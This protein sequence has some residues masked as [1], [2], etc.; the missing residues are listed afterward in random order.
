MNKSIA[1]IVVALAVLAASLV[2]TAPPA[3][4]APK[5]YASCAKLRAD[6]PKGV[7]RTKAAAQR[8]VKAGFRRPAVKPVVYKKNRRLDPDRDR[9]A[10]EKRQPKPADPWVNMPASSML[11]L[12]VMDF[13]TGT[14]LTVD[15]FAA[16][17]DTQDTYVDERPVL[18]DGTPVSGFDGDYFTDPALEAGKTYSL[19]LTVDTPAYW[20]CS[21]YYEEGCIR[22]GNTRDVM[23][24]KFEHQ[25]DSGVIKRATK[26]SWRR[27]YR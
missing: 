22:T 4:A 27:L 26:V 11:P 16:I 6:F 10:C 21:V 5:R 9:T 17:F 24:W 20:D 15:G 7:A 12:D 19:T 23:T 1:A 14:S 18:S 2:V 3:A 8:Q 25:A 13:G